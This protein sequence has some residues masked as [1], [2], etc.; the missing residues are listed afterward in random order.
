ML[1]GKIRESYQVALIIAFGIAIRLA[2]IP[3][4]AST[5]FRPVDVYYVDTQAAK[6]IVHFSNPYAQ[7]YII[8]G[9]Q[10]T[11]LAYLPFVSIYYAP[12]YKLLGDI[13]YGNIFADVLIM[14]SLY[15]IAKS[16]NRGR[17]VW[18]PLIYAVF[19]VSIL[20]T[21]ISST[22]MVVGT[23]FLI[24]ALAATL[25][26]KYLIASVFLGLG[27]ATNQ[28]VILSVPVIAYYY[29]KQK[30][31]V[32]LSLAMMISAAIILPF[33]LVMPSQFVYDVF[34]YQFVRSLQPNGVFSLYSFIHSIS[35]VGLSSWIRGVLFLVPALLTLFWFTKDLGRFTLTVGILLL[36]G[37][38]MLP[39]D[40]FWN[41]FLPALS[42]GCGLVP[43]FF[44]RVNTRRS[45]VKPLVSSAP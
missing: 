29:W 24:V 27:I 32:F 31:F 3:A 5:P 8:H 39:V 25:K 21:S 35:G 22:N 41:Y 23:A 44:A 26:R 2:A 19:P 4:F 14:L 10:L 34:E 13:R 11:I 20:L 1:V 36:L 9:S 17:A 16:I 45:S 18:S 7:T 15:W 40:G 37:A 43:S 33:F 6:Y 28:F 38:F 42:V 12:F 30:K